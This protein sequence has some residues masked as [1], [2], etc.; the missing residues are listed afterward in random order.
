MSQLYPKQK[1][2]DFAQKY[3]LSFH[4]AKAH[5]SHQLFLQKPN[6]NSKGS[7]FS[8][9]LTFRPITP[10]NPQTSLSRLHRDNDSDA[11]KSQISI[12][13]NEITVLKEQIRPL[14]PLQNTVNIIILN[15]QRTQESVEKLERLLLPVIPEKKRLAKT[16]RYSKRPAT[17]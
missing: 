16:P 17:V 8:P 2:L 7:Y 14:L 15:S 10:T 3:G 6:L 11:I 1:I 4:G 5:I 12:L 13:Q 9:L